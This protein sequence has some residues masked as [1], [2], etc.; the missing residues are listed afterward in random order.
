MATKRTPVPKKAT[1]SNPR[2]IRVMGVDPGI[3][4]MGVAILEW[5][6]EA[7]WP[8]ADQLKLIKTPGTPKK[9]L[10]RKATKGRVSDDDQRRVKL[11]YEALS[12]LATDIVAIGA[13][14]YTVGAGGLGGNSWKT[15]FSYQSVCCF[16]WANDIQLYVQRPDDL[17]RQ[18]VGKKAGGKVQVMGKLIAEIN[19]LDIFL[20]GHAPGSWEHLSDA[21][22]HALLALRRYISEHNL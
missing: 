20:E 16:A 1:T 18:I 9:V 12:E 4:S 3:A 13:E 6:P 5:S 7:P 22:G 10:N 21:A 15:C 17:K 14:V 8:K 11:Q 2:T 19:G